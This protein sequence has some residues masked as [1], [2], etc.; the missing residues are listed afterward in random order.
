[1]LRRSD[2][3]LQ[4]LHAVYAKAVE[5]F[6]RPKRKDPFKTLPL[7]VVQMILCR[8][9]F[10]DI[11]F[12]FG[13]PRSLQ[14]LISGSYSINVSKPWSKLLASIPTLWTNLDFIAAKKTVL[15]RSIRKYIKQ[16]QGLPTRVTLPKYANNLQHFITTRCRGLYELV[17][18]G[19]IVGT[20]MLQAA[21][22]VANL[23][24]I[25]TGRHCVITSDTLDQLLENGKALERAEFHNVI[26]STRHSGSWNGD[27]SK[28]R[29]LVMVFD[30]ERRGNPSQQI[31]DLDKLVKK[32]PNLR[33]LT[34][35]SDLGS[36]TVSGQVPSS[37]DFSGL[38][39]L[40]DLDISG[41]IADRGPIFPSSLLSLNISN[42][43][44]TPGDAVPNRLTR[45]VR[46]SISDSR[47]L[48]DDYFK[49]IIDANKGNLTHV[50]VEGFW[51]GLLHELIVSGYFQS[52]I[53]L[54]L[55]CCS[56]N[57]AQMTELAKHAPNIKRLSLKGTQIT[58]VGV[59]TL[60]TALKDKLEYLCLDNCQ[61]CSPDANTWAIAMGV[62]TSFKFPDNSRG[63]RKVRQ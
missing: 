33:K 27:L 2:L 30:R 36:L 12:V 19:G 22:C 52:V 59:K 11:W 40:E 61:K 16:G 39:L 31:L 50:D 9:E 56:V 6:D 53:E 49:T 34:L 10:T 62:K 44:W 4:L 8:L 24:T 20:T 14:T 13:C 18:P 48:D 21:P 51:E 42:N 25:I 54:K 28:L 23:K 15:E 35:H 17:I 32:T 57:D 1:M 58:G 7:E 43:I 37:A 29:T 3:T 60:V 46:L 47:I 38:K 63:G 55:G 26:G 41:I 5:F 45:L